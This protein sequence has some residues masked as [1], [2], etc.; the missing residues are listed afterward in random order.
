MKSD[1]LT[2]EGMTC[3]AC[4]S[5]IEKKLRKITGVTKANVNLLAKRLDLT[6][7]STKI[8]IE[9]IIF[10]INEMGYKA[11]L[12]ESSKIDYNNDLEIKSLKKRFI[13][14]L[15]FTVPL[16][17]IAMTPMVLMLLNLSVPSIFDMMKYG[18]QIALLQ[19]MLVVSIM[20]INYKY[21]KVGFKSLLNLSPNMDSLISIGTLT[22]FLYGIYVTILIISGDMSN[23]L[24]FESVGVIL[25]LITMGK[26][27]EAKSKCKTSMAISKLLNLAPKKATIIR[28]EKEIVIF[29]EDI[30]IGD[31]IVVKPGEKFSVD[32]IIMNGFATI[33]ES[34]L[35]GES[36]P[37]D[38]TIG[39]NVIGGTINKSGNVTYK[40]NKTINNS[41]LAEIVKLVD[42]AQKDKAP[43][44]ALADVVSSYFVPIVIVIA[45]LSSISWYI[46]G[47]SISFVLTIFVSVLIIACPCALGLATPT[48]IMVSTGKG[49]EN[50]ILI[51]SGESLENAY[52]I[53]TVIFDKTGTITYGKP[54]VT[55]VITLNEM[56]EEEVIK[57]AFSLEKKS[58]HPLGLAIINK[59]KEMGLSE[60][61][62][63][64]FISISGFGVEGKVN[65][66]YLLIGNK[67]YMEKNNIEI[68]NLSKI[69]EFSNEGKTPI[70]ISVNSKLSSIICIRD[71]IKT[72][73]SDVVKTLENKNIEVIMLTGDNM[74]TS[75]AIAN[76]VGIKRVISEVLPQEKHEVIKNLKL[77]GKKVAMVGDGINDAIALVESDLGIAIGNGTDIAN[78]TANI[79][80]MKE[81]LFGVVNIIDLS[82]RTIINIKQ[83][84]FWAFIYNIIGIFFAS[85]VFY[86]IG[87]P[88]LNPIVSGFAMAMSSVSVLSNTLRLNNIKFK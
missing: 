39:D 1:V 83:N 61:N 44:A 78:E 12:E 11:I 81:D 14:S 6:F 47:E 31:L 52:K 40:A 70:Y 86:L 27:L 23:E 33:D 35:T 16:V 3:A 66:K 62:V 37:V 67:K 58:E 41:T 45:I 87:G 2:I 65:S 79:V 28:D 18:S 60:E 7:D 38:K 8:S 75:T 84:L 29:V 54:V 68:T 50:G 30:I 76:E 69:D 85:G 73:A 19:L 10:I 32:G 34:M 49:A 71:E 43:I 56:S 22:A 46:S 13:L 17:I 80:L 15:I 63:E 59:A 72:N 82:K 25:T 77:E 55:D 53:N 57:L 4:Q 51:K 9:D 48:A 21:Y 24:Y 36:I 64:E 26:Y 88:L 74:K 42:N 20:I 5:G